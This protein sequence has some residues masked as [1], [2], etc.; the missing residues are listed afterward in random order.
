M[1]YTILICGYPAVACRFGKAGQ[2]VPED[3]AEQFWKRY[4]TRQIPPIIFGSTRPVSET[5]THA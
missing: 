1:K 4:I 5:A 3:I 2:I